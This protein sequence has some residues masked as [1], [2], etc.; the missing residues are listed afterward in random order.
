MQWIEVTPLPEECGACTET[1]RY[2]CD[3]AGKRWVLQRRQE[4]LLKRKGILKSI[5]RLEK[6]L[7]VIDNELIRPGK[8]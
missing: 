3:Y 5:A 4:L 8:E 7:E 1:D 2:N 6:Q